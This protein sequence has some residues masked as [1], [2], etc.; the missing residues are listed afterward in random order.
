MPS[1][2]N[3]LVKAFGILE[4][5]KLYSKIKLKPSGWLHL[6]K[7][8]TGFYLRPHS[9][10]L[11]TFNQVF[12]LD[13]YNIKLPFLPKTIIDAG[14]NIGLSSAYFAHRFPQ[15]QIVAIERINTFG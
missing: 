8:K 7:Y 11:Y 13:Q 15:S 2:F 6:N 12:I 9:S 3:G 14:A 1:R 10:D 4:A 5:I